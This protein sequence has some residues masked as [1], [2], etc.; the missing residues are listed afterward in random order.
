[1]ISLNIIRA[2]LYQP[3]LS[4]DKQLFA[5]TLI[6]RL[7]RFMTPLNYSKKSPTDTEDGGDEGYCNRPSEME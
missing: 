6:N 5:F 4:R 3:K 7:I 2:L 1:M